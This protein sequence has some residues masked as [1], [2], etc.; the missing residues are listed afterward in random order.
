MTFPTLSSG[1]MKVYPPLNTQALAMYPATL[2][3]SFITRVLK[4]INDSEQRWV[5][6][7]ELFSAVLQFHGVN[8]Y[9]MSVLLDFFEQ[10]KGAYVDTALLNV[11][12]ITI[13][14]VN[15][16]WCCFDQDE[17]DIE[18]NQ[19]LT[20]SFQLSIKQLRPN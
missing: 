10:V 19:G 2:N 17:I 4:F 3:R 5:V 14:S 11:F 6:R 13:D 15:Y 9:D 8:G 18:S 7:S 20:F 1:S 12:D 16:K